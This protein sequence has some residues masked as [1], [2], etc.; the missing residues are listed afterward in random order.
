[1]VSPSMWSMFSP[2]NATLDAFRKEQGALPFSYEEVGATRSR[3][4]DGYD[5]DRN[6]AVLGH[7]EA[8]YERAVEGLISW[9]MF[10]VWSRIFPDKLHPSAGTVVVLVFQLLGYWMSAARVVYEVDEGLSADVQRRRGFAYGTLPGH[11]EMGE[12]CFT[13]SLRH[14]GAVVYE[15]QAFSR[16]RILP[17]RL[18]KPLTRRWQRKFVRDSQ[19]ALR[20]YANAR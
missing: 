2:T 12:E 18:L 9:R 4:P 7:G 1:M 11:V 13:V 10:P 8:V 6:E 20:A 5:H 16:P 17:A 15:L 19:A 14:D 3:F